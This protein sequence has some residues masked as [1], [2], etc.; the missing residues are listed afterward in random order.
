[1][2]VQDFLVR[3]KGLLSLCLLPPCFLLMFFQ[4]LNKRTLEEQQNSI[5]SINHAVQHHSCKQQPKKPREKRKQLLFL[6]GKF[7]E[8]LWGLFFHKPAWAPFKP[9][10]TFSPACQSTVQTNC[11]RWTTSFCFQLATCLCHLTTFPSCIAEMSCWILLTLRITLYFMPFYHVPSLQFETPLILAYPFSD[12]DQ[13]C[14][15]QSRQSTHPWPI[16]N[17]S[18]SPL[19][20]SPFFLIISNSQF[21]FSWQPQIT[22]PTFTFSYQLQSQYLIPKPGEILSLC[23]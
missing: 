6:N 8:F 19:F 10:P 22:E 7:S 13:S 14:T 5:K 2:S 16:D 21:A 3:L 23:A 11:I 4:I 18:D 15:L 9:M 17:C 20:C 1:M 12:R